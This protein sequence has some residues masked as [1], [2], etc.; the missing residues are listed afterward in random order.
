MELGSLW[1]NKDGH[2]YNGR[3]KLDC[4]IVLKGGVEYSLF[5]NEVDKSQNVNLPDFRLVLKSK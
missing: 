5:L 4:D 2:G 3:L 1:K